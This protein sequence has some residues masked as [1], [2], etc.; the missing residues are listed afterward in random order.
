MVQAAVLPISALRPLLMYREGVT[1]F[2]LRSGSGHQFF[3]SVELVF[4]SPTNLEPQPCLIRTIISKLYSRFIDLLQ[5]KDCSVK[6]L[7][8]S[9]HQYSKSKRPLPTL[10][11]RSS[12]PFGHLS[13]RSTALSWAMSTCWARAPRW[14]K[15]FGRFGRVPQDGKSD[16]VDERPTEV[17]GPYRKLP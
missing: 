11:S 6:I 7:D 16:V 3:P 14:S 10:L 2:H 13:R 17:E 5:V 15:P 4:N 9:S 8:Q 12:L 1:F